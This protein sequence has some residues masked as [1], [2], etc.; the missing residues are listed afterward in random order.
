MNGLEVRSVGRSPKRSRGGFGGDFTRQNTDIRKHLGET[1]P[2]ARTWRLPV[3]RCRFGFSGFDLLQRALPG[4]SRWYMP[5]R[6]GR[7]RGTNAVPADP[8]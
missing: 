8:A 3:V 4:D 7:W 1:T 6:Y 5:W 2:V